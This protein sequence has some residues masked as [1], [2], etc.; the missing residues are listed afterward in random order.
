MIGTCGENDPPGF[1]ISS[2]FIDLIFL[3]RKIRAK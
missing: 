2:A 3:A 1:D